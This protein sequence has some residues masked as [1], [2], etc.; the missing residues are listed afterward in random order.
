LQYLHSPDVNREHRS[1]ANMVEAMIRDYC[2]RRS[3]A[4]DEQAVRHPRKKGR[5]L[6]AREYA[7]AER[8]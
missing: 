4:I 3:V 6:A 5:S 8:E 2:G 1:V 7:W